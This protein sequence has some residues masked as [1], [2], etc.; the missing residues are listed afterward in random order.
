MQLDNL[1]FVSIIVPV[2]NG[3]KII[4]ECIESLVN[5][6]YPKDKY[7]IIIVDNNSK[8]K[9]AEIIKKYPIRCLLEDKIQSSYAARN[10]G[11]KNAKGEILAFTDSDCVAYKNWLVN[12]VEGWEGKEIGFAGEINEPLPKTPIEKYHFGRYNQKRC[13]FNKEYHF[14][15]TANVAFKKEIFELIG[16]FRNDLVSG[17]DADLSW[18]IFNAGYEI[19]YNAKALVLHR[20]KSTL[21]DQFKQTKRYAFGEVHLS[22]TYPHIAKSLEKPL[23]K[24]VRY[25]LNDFITLIYR[26]LTFIFK[27]ERGYYL[28][29]PV[30]SIVN[31]YARY[32]GIMVG[33]KYVYGNKK[34]RVPFE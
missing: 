6:D 2:Y 10:T 7:E 3:E 9:T 5:Q 4:A 19:K 25:V 21:V 8:D 1:P 17:G 22:K 24:F 16:M 14:A 26:S 30:I 15:I 18:R 34:A 20:H 28:S 27:K 13:L 23:F 31:K 12:L 32:S 33:F 11:I 29:E